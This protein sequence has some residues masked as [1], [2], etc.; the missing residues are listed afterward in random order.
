MCLPFSDLSERTLEQGTHLGFL[1]EIVHN[2]NGYRCGYVRVLPGHPWFGKGYDDVGAE[3]HGGLTFAQAGSSCP[4]HGPE[5][6]WWLG[7]DCAH[8]D[9]LP[10][11]KLPGSARMVGMLSG[12]R[13]YG[14]EV[15]SQEYARRECFRLAEQ[16]AAAA[17]AA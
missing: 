16:A 9:D 2:G 8:C 3:V 13:E 17:S 10:D 1:Y 15:R 7:F 12:L 5:E 11:P 4:T 6:E 14:A